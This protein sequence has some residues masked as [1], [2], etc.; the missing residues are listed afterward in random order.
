[1]TTCTGCGA[2][3]S[4]VESDRPSC[5]KCGAPLV[6]APENAY[7]GAPPVETSSSGADAEVRA[8]TRRLILILLAVA[9][10]GIII[11]IIVVVLGIIFLPPA[12]RR[13]R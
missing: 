9:A 13:R 10:V 2:V 8:G 3:L 4:A 12:E 7:R 5:S 1:V 11:P 6:R